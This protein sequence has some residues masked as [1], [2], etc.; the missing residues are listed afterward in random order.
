MKDDYL[1]DKNGS[2]PEIERLE[3]LLSVF[4]YQEIAAPALPIANPVDVAEKTS[5]WRFRFAY[6][7]GASAAVVTLIGAW[8]LFSGGRQGSENELSSSAPAH[9]QPFEI[10][11]HIRSPVEEIGNDKAASPPT[12]KYRRTASFSARR[13]AKA[14]RS[15]DART[16]LTKE[17]KYA[18]EQLMLALSITGSK[19]KIVQDTVNGTDEKEDIT[20]KNKR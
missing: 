20:T 8:V 18:Y 7:F 6:A 3:G 10:G 9:D 15:I 13:H 16:A 12:A 1:Y 2:N 17:E 4:R 19:L 5:I 11:V 14:V